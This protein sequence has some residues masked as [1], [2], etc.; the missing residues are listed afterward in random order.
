MSDDYCYDQLILP[1]CGCQ[2]LLAFATI[3]CA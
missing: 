2:P 3:L 1:A